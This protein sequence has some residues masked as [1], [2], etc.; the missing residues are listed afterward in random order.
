M[1]F[2]SGEAEEFNERLQAVWE[3]G[4]EPGSVAGGR[5]IQRDEAACAA[6]SA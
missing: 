1:N 6:A 2:A 3:R 5:E 4:S